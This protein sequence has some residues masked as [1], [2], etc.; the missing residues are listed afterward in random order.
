M[1]G[2]F[3]KVRFNAGSVCRCRRVTVDGD[4]GEI[5]ETDGESG[6]YGECDESGVAQ[7][8]VTLEGY[9]R[10]A[11]LGPIIEGDLLLNVLIAW[12]GNVA[13]PVVDKR[14]LFPKLKVLKSNT[15]GEVRGGSITYTLTCKSSG[16]YAPPGV[17][18]PGARA[19]AK[20][21]DP[22]EPFKPAKAN[23]A[24]AEP[25]PEPAKAA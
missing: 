21:K 19:A 23:T 17:N 8:D 13:A 20:A 6:G 11:D 14:H 16:P 2:I 7:A 1:T 10:R 4:V 22:R 18:D 15:T 24:N 5:D 3:I 25:E 9:R 12:D